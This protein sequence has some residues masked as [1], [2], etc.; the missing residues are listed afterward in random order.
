MIKFLKPLA[1]LS[2]FGFPV[3]VVLYRLNLVAFPVSFQ[4][5]S[6]SLYL[7]VAVFI[8]SMVASFIM[9]KNK[10]KAHTARMA[11][12]IAILPIIGIGSQAFTAKSVPFIH[13][14]S[15]D[16]VNPPAFDKVISLRNEQHNPLAFDG[17]KVL[18]KESGV[19]LAQVQNSAY[20]NV[21]THISELAPQDAHAKAK[22]VA[23]ALGWELVNSDPEAGIIEATQT[24]M[25]W[26]FKDD[27]VVRITAT[28]EG[29][30][31]IDLHSVSRIG[32][33]DLGANAKRIEAFLTQFKG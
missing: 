7:A 24:T 17:N 30:S 32:G 33:S 18:D 11:A 6:Y 14:I 9:R 22:S 5:I 1:I 16:T 19:T 23:E 31:A 4:V 20:P 8:L 10:D 21:K 3:A 29:K 26:G 27:V 28:P 12:L 2:L 25:I 13:N 15:T